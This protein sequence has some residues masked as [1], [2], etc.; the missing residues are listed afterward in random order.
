MADTILYDSAF[1]LFGDHATAKVLAA[2]EAGEWPAAL[3]IAVEE[4]GY[5]DVLAE[6]PAAMV[7]AATIL[8][9][10]GHHAAPIPLAETMLA[11]WLCA[12][13]GLEAPAGPLTVAPVEP[14]DRILVVGDTLVGRAG[15]VPWGRDAAATV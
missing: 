7:E 6:G 4:A 12:A 11:R 5:L 15:F 13:C 9:V 8:R 14:D 1:R 10:A 2:A 3:W